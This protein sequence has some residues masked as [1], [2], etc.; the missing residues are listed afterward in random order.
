MFVLF[1]LN[2]YGIN[3]ALVRAL[4]R[5]PR[6]PGDPSTRGSRSTSFPTGWELLGF[7]W[8]AMAWPGDADDDVIVVG[9][10][11]LLVALGRLGWMTW[12]GQPPRP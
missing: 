12:R 9:A 11:L 2:R 6:T 1:V 5:A 7:I 8:L 3:L 10:I 4:P